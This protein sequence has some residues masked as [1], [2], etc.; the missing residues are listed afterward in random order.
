MLLIRSSCILLVVF[1]FG[2]QSVPVY[3]TQYILE[4]PRDSQGRSCVLSCDVPRQQC[5][6]S[7]AVQ[8]KTCN[9]QQQAKT[10]QWQLCL[11]T[12]DNPADCQKPEI[13]DCSQVGAE[14][15]EATY[16][17]CYQECG[18]EVQQRRVCTEGC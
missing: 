2:C 15:C 1:L 12:L 8:Q 3:K 18:G 14:I 6:A 13:K 10:N 16:R 4:P 17:S 11:D 9:T 7:S 5:S